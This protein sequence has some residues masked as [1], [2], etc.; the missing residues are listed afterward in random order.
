MQSV[1]DSKIQ[2]PHMFPTVAAVLEQG[3]ACVLEGSS[4]K[5][6]NDKI[7]IKLFYHSSDFLI[8]SCKLKLMG[9]VKFN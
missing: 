5:G 9:T 8:E 1:G 3:R 7:G 6:I 2:L 4:L